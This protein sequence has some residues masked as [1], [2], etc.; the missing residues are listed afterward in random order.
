MTTRFF[1]RLSIRS[2]LALLMTIVLAV[3]AVAVFIYFPA[4]L[5]KQAIRAMSQKAV[6][7]SGLTAM[8]LGQP[9]RNNDRAA[10]TEVFESLRRDPDL[11]YFLILK[12]DGKAFATYNQSVAND[13]GYS[14]I[15]MSE[16][17]PGPGE[18][19]TSIGTSLNGTVLQTRTPIPYPGK[20]AGGVIQG[21]S[22]P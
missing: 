21:F 14:S 22:L 19:A 18:V 11:L 12:P 13:A 7:T 15:A 6:A 16:L 10:V 17:R 4:R 1:S 3:F 8:M 20:H 9:V 5:R 2:R